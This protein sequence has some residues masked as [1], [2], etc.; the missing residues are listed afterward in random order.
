MYLIPLKRKIKVDF[1]SQLTLATVLSSFLLLGGPLGLGG[2]GLDGLNLEVVKVFLCF[3]LNSL[4]RRESSMSSMEMEERMSATS[5]DS[6]EVDVVDTLFMVDKNIIA[7]R[8]FPKS[9]F[10]LRLRECTLATFSAIAHSK[11]EFLPTCIRAAG[12]QRRRP[13]RWASW[14]SSLASARGS[15]G[16]PQS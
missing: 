8:P 5:V 10:L 4:G 13:G 1:F 12:M 7:Q 14:S 3:S 2:L 6:V 16:S 9:T 11:V 15:S